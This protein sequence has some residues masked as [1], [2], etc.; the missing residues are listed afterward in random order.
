MTFVSCFSFVKDFKTM[1]LLPYCGQ[2]K[3]EHLQW[4]DKNQKPDQF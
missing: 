1:F 2:P 3:E 4:I